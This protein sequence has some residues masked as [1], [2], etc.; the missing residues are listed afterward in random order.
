MDY[1]LSLQKIIQSWTEYAH[2]E[3]KTSVNRSYSLNFTKD[4]ACA[5]I[6]ARRS[7]KSTLAIQ[8]IYHQTKNFL[9]INFE[10]PFFSEH[11]STQVLEDLIEE[12][13]VLFNKRPD[14]IIYDEIHNIPNWER[15]ARKFIDKKRGVLVITGS[16]AK[17]LSSELSSSLTGR[18]LTHEV[19]PL[20]FTE[21]IQFLKI[22]SD[23]QQEA[24][25]YYLKW[26]G[27]P[28][29]VLETNEKVRNEILQQYY[30]D[31]TLKD[32]IKRNEIRDPRALLSVF[33][34]Y[35]TN[36]SSLHSYNKIKNAFGLSAHA[37]IAYTHA[38]MEAFL[39]FEVSLYNKNLKIQSRNPKKIYAIDTG[40][41]NANA[42]S[43]NEDRWKLLENFVFLEY[44]KRGYQL[45]YHKD[46][47]ECDFL[48]TEKYKPIKAI[49][50]TESLKN[51]SVYEREI[52]GLKE[53]ME[54]HNINEGLIVTLNEEGVKKFPAGTIKIVSAWKYFSKFI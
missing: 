43:S 21:Y 26:G 30:S 24:F 8:A 5:L 31:S 38:L 50:V 33:N 46:K 54:K 23:K 49:Q 2:S 16:S 12:Y 47:F 18:N 17:M 3:A 45:Y 52:E 48:I 37:P 39:L 9:Y 20:S 28:R 4:L 1:N 42:T 53:A 15:W 10:D 7:G 27:F 19:W 51:N 25:T 35:L 11:T 32:V 13:F 34:Y 29:V 44:R 40:F 14:Y 6:G 36:I 41:R 22:K